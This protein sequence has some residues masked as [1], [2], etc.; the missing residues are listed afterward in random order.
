MEEY[1]SVF[2]FVKRLWPFGFHR[3]HG[4]ERNH[5]ANFFIFY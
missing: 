5:P 4:I 2:G 3:F 1:F